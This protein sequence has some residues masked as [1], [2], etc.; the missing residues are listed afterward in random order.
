MNKQKIEQMRNSKH[1]NKVNIFDS[2]NEEPMLVFVE[3]VSVTLVR[4]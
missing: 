2:A 4:T 3:S 1:G